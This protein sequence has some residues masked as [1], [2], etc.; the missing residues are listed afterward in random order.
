MPATAELAALP[1]H[2][3]RALDALWLEAARE[4]GFPV[5]RGG[6]AYV[7]WDGRALHLA[8]D[9]HL[10]DDDTV[11]QLVVHEVCHALTQGPGRL[12]QPDFG[13]DNTSSVDDVRES[14]CLRVQ[15]HLLGTVGLRRVLYPTTVVAPF[16]FALPHDALAGGDADSVPLAREALCRAAR[17]PYSPRLRQAHEASAALVGRPHHPT[18][19]PAGDGDTRCGACAFRSP[20]GLCRKADRRVRVKGTEPG[21]ARFEAALDCRT[22]AACCRSAYDTVLLGPRALLR[23]RH[24]ELIESVDGQ[25][26]VRRDGDHCAALDGAPGGPFTCR[27]HADRPPTCRDFTL[28][29]AHCF[30]ARRRV[31]LS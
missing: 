25:L 21:C 29:S 24:P 1:A 15:A 20:G 11:A 22:C 6:D 9:R 7:H 12:S 14:A 13:L 8:D 26:R 18:G 4:L 5:V 28:G 17:P 30:T 16:Y 3:R 31:G 27:V 2:T 23:R 19:L 10:D